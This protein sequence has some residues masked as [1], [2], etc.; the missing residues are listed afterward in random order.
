MMNGVIERVERQ[1]HREVDEQDRDGHRGE[2]A[3]ERLVL[4]LGDTREP[5]V[6][7]RRDLAGRRRASSISSG[8]RLTAPVSTL[9]MSALIDAAGEPS[10]RV[11]DPWAFA[12]S[13]V[14]IWPSGTLTTVP[15]GT[16]G[17]S[18]DVTWSGSRRTTIAACRLVGRWTGRRRPDERRADLLATCAVVRPTRIDLFGSRVTRISGVP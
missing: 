12:C 5:D 17:A 6:D 13:T 9:A 8:P 18:T 11:I 3:A 2:Q 14:A 16:S 7:V 1:D 15:T 10:M 4:L